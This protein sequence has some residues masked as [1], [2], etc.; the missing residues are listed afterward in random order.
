[1]S[2]RISA[3]L[4]VGL[5]VFCSSGCSVVPQ[6]SL[7]QSHMQSMKLYKQN[8]ALGS[9]LQTA[10][11]R[12][13]NLLAERSTL[14]QNYVGLLNRARNQKSPLSQEDTRRLEEL[15]KANPG[16]YFDPLTGI[17]KVDAD[18]LFPLGSA[19][20]N[21]K[22]EKARV[23]HKFSHIMNQGGAKRLNIL[24]VGHTDDVPIEKRK[25][26]SKHPTNWHLSTNRANAV[27]LKLAQF[28]IAEHRMGAAGFSKYQPVK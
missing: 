16:F 24:V 2:V 5:L 23:L 3:F 13:D 21:P 14:Q 22:S 20:I 18:I 17:S 12:L 28:G 25:T 1:M 4:A 6:Q 9:K 19:R 27:V 10:N 8:Q 26:K 15:S 11:Q 7:Q